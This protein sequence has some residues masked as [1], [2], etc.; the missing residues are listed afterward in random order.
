MGENLGVN[1]GWNLQWNHFFKTVFF[2]LR[3]SCR[4]DN[5]YL[6]VIWV[7]NKLESRQQ[8]EGFIMW[9]DKKRR[10]CLILAAFLLTGLFSFSLYGQNNNDPMVLMYDVTVGIDLLVEQTANDIVSDEL[11]LD[12]TGIMLTDAESTVDSDF[13]FM[14]EESFL[15][16]HDTAYDEVMNEVMTDRFIVKYKSGHEESFKE[17]SLISESVI[18]TLPE[19]ES[20]FDIFKPDAG[21]ME[22]ITLPQKV[23]P[24]EYA[25]KLIELGA[26]SDIEYIQPDFKVKFAAFDSAS[27]FGGIGNGKEVLIEQTNGVSKD[28]SD[29]TGN[30]AAKIA[31]ALIDTGVDITHPDL[32]NKLWTAETFSANEALSDSIFVYANSD[33]VRESMSLYEIEEDTLIHG[34]NFVDD[35]NVVYDANRGFEQ[36][37]GTHI[38][39]IISGLSDAG[40]ALYANQDD[41]QIMV[42]KVFENGDAYTSDII[43]AI[44]FAEEHGAKIINCSWGGT[45]YNRALYEAMQKSSALFVCAAGNARLDMQQIP[46]YPAAFDLD[47]IISVGGI[48]AD[49]GLS[50]FSNYGT[51]SVDIGALSRDVTST[52]PIIGYAKQ[53]GT[54]MAAGVVS[55]A[56]AALLNESALTA[57][58]LKER[59]MD[60]ADKISSLTDY[61]LN[62]GRLNLEA[63]LAGEVQNDIVTVEVEEDF[64]PAGYDEVTDKIRLFQSSDIVQVAAADQHSLLRKSDGSVWSW[65]ATDFGQTGQNSYKQVDNIGRV[66]GLTDIIDISASG[67]HSLALKADG[68]VWA[69]G[70]NA[71]GQIG[72]GTSTIYN[73]V[74]VPVQ[75]TGLQGVTAISAGSSHSLAVI[76]G[77][78]WAW[79]SNSHNELGIST[80]SFYSSTPIHV[81]DLTNIVYVEAGAAASLAI[82][83]SGNVY[84]W[85]YNYYGQLGN[86]QNNTS[87]SEIFQVQNIPPI[88]SASMSLGHVLALTEDHQV[89]GWGYNGSRQLGP[90]TGSSLSMTPFQISDLPD[91]LS[92]RT[93]QGYS[94]ALSEDGTVWAW[95]SSSLWQLGLNINVSHIE[96]PTQIPSLSNVESLATADIHSLVITQDGSLYGWGSN[97]YGNV[98]GVATLYNKWPVN[99]WQDE[100]SVAGIAAGD[101]FSQLNTEDGIK[102]WGQGSSNQFGLGNYFNQTALVNVDV[103]EADILRSGGNH[104]I[105]LIDDSVYVWGSNSNLQLGLGNYSSQFP[106]ILTGLS[107]VAKVSASRYS[108]FAIMNDGMV[109]GWGDNQY[110]HL[111]MTT[112]WLINAPTQIPGLS[113]ITDITGGW[114]F[115]L[116]LK[117]DGTVWAMGRNNYGQLGDGTT[118]NRTTPVQ[119]QGLTNVIA[120]SAGDEFGLAL[121]NDGTV[122]YWGG[123][124]SGVTKTTPTQLQGLTGITAISAKYEHGLAIK[125]NGTVWAFG[126]NRYGQLGNGTL[127]GSNGTQ[128]SWLSNVVQISAGR[129]H[130]LALR[131]NGTVYGWGKNVSYCASGTPYIL[132]YPE[133]V[134]ILALQIEVAAPESLAEPDGGIHT[135]YEY[136]AAGNLIR[137]YSERLPE[138]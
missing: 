80:S 87:T 124:N 43:E 134:D 4:C 61:I 30:E 50:Y 8:R 110:N 120:I 52:V 22:Y 135:V 12:D 89:W 114:L 51:D 48:N 63:S 25:E 47:N 132:E 116:A 16:A 130:S 31:V 90:P 60:G 109:M 118:T 137:T 66:R 28:I 107:N 76:D 64:N 13:L 88:E 34:W 98:D 37:H 133:P 14:R 83:E 85:G 138:E 38:A 6:S 126:S 29:L 42:L 91:I 111:G 79:G 18:L 68:T 10:W 7:A 40:T 108:S 24:V 121:K 65:G 45:E 122:W 84:A 81:T 67:K 96:T 69:W 86:G 78:V 36:A 39:G 128:V 131:S 23:N 72:N 73:G 20:F 9:E 115:T 19:K 59:L 53:T 77:E 15:N 100:E 32:R 46:V 97:T 11:G 105:A 26:D 92:V 33:D 5:I 119:V 101:E 136:D 75:V 106:V 35:N 62:G 113:Q 82:D 56:A 58:E 70:D 21:A 54:S 94:T 71:R 2:E 41:V 27:S 117:S 129:Y 99:I 1:Y 125:N 74:P 17:K 3:F 49:G 102:G 93:G 112:N 44:A 57:T 55:G 104:S 95:G 123:Y 103:P 127:N